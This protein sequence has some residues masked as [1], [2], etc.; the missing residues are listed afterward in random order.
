MP[1]QQARQY[2]PLS[3]SLSLSA[4]CLGTLTFFNYLFIL[5]F[6]SSILCNEIMGV[7]QHRLE[8]KDACTIFPIPSKTGVNYN[9]KNCNIYIKNQRDATWQYV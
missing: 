9:N 1:R 5:R 6:K 8:D 7:L 2:C 3:L 4:I